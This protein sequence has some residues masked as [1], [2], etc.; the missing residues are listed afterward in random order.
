MF[1]RPS[2]PPITKVRE[3]DTFVN[4]LSNLSANLGEENS[5]P[6]SSKHIMYEFF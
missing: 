1:E 2:E 6:V 4:M 3:L 5:L